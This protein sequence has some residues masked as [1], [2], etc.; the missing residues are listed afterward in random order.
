MSFH[1]LAIGMIVGF[2]GAQKL[3]AS[4]RTMLIGTGIVFAGQIA[5]I[6]TLAGAH[7]GF[8]AWWLSPARAVVGI[9]M[10]IT[11]A[12]F[13]DIV[14]GAATQSGASCSVRARSL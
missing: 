13:F 4:R 9:G 2:I 6:A 12:P 10:G 5:I 8:D 3:G 7:A 1:T 14:L 11:M